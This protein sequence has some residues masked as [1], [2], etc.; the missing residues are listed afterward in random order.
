ME[1]K[2]FCQLLVAYL[3][4]ELGSQLCLRLTF[5]PQTSL[6]LLLLRMAKPFPIRKRTKKKNCCDYKLA[7]NR[8]WRIKLN[9]KKSTHFTFTKHV[10]TCPAVTLNGKDIPLKTSNALESTKLYWLIA[11][12]SQVTS[13]NCIKQ[14]QIVLRLIVAF[15]TK[16]GLRYYHMAFMSSS[17][18]NSNPSHHWRLNGSSGLYVLT[19]SDCLAINYY[20]SKFWRLQ[21]LFSVY[22]KPKNPRQNLLTKLKQSNVQPYVPLD[23]LKDGI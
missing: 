15:V 19:S 2:E 16:M 5:S 4:S 7:E 3:S 17:M 6:P 10:A 11:H 18:S 12:K 1:R 21:N 8:N 20:N 14:L 13:K 23:F 9:Q 22:P